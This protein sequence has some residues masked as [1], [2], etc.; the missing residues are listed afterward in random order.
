LSFTQL[1]K[2]TPV[3][4]AQMQ[5]TNGYNPSDLQWKSK[6]AAGV[7]VRIAE[8]TSADRETWHMREAVGCMVFSKSN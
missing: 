5:T 3:F 4:I 1:H 8:E 2:A 7:E 6:N